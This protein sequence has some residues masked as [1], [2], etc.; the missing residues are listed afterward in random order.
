MIKDHS[1]CEKKIHQFMGYSF[2]LSARDLLYAP[3]HKQD[4]T[5]HALYYTSCGAQAGTRNSSMDLPCRIDLMSHRTMSRHSTMELHLTP[6]TEKKS[7]E[8]REQG[9]CYDI[10]CDH[11]SYIKVLLNLQ[12]SQMEN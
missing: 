8:G 10:C 12:V 9:S 7:G 3:S 1:D 11:E 2:Q 5:K 4:S 6:K